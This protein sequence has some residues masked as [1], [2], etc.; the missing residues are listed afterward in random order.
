MKK[1][2]GIYSLNWGSLNWVSGVYLYHLLLSTDSIKIS[3][4]YLVKKFQRYGLKYI[5]SLVVVKVG[6]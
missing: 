3:A 2:A 6:L 5:Y 1:G 4:Y